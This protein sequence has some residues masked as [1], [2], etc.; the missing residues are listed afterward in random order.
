MHQT[1][2]MVVHLLQF[3]FRR[4]NAAC[5]PLSQ[6]SLAVLEFLLIHLFAN[7]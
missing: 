6:F 1:E 2:F 4:I 7:Q 5:R 3:K